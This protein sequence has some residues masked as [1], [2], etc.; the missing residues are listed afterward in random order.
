MYRDIIND[1]V[2]LI[3]LPDVV[4]IAELLSR[5]GDP[6]IKS[7]RLEQTPCLMKFVSRKRAA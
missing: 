5:I 1:Q 4:N 6:G 2:S 3:G 7:P